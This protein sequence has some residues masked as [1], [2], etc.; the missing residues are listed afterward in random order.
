[1]GDRTTC[2]IRLPSSLKEQAKAI[3]KADYEEYPDNNL[4]EFVFEEVNY[5]DMPEERQELE[6]AGIPHDFSW[7]SGSQYAAGEA[8]TRYTPDGD[9]I[10][11]GGYET[12]QKID[13][14][15]LLAVLEST[16]SP[17]DQ[18]E[19]IAALIYKTKAKWEPLPWDNQIEFGKVHK[20]KLLIEE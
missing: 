12:D 9:I 5:G 8:H 3:L 16:L 15:D 4:V 18:L 6:D 1:M 10:Y 20:L 2:Q 11:T 19:Q 13:Y 14:L 17:E 7:G